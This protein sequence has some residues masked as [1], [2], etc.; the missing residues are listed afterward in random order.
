M[1]ACSSLVVFA[2]D[3]GS[4][5]T[6]Q[7]FQLVTNISSS[8]NEFTKA[9]KLLDSVAGEPNVWSG[10]AGNEL[11]SFDRRRRFAKHFFEHFVV[12]GT[13]LEQIKKMVGTNANWISFK[14]AEKV[15]RE[16]NMGVMPSSLLEGKSGF[17]IPILA[18]K[19]GDYHLVIFLSLDTDVEVKDI[20]AELT[21]KTKGDPA[22]NAKIAAC[23]NWDSEYLARRDPS[24]KYSP[25]PF[26]GK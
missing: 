26:D 25:W 11:Y 10:L 20:E 14:R 24:S 22:A 8:S 2:E 21:G 19:G 23:E 18:G 5:S 4:L 1:L 12:P 6:N 3:I 15:Q 9:I 17:T 7:A 16:W 13:T